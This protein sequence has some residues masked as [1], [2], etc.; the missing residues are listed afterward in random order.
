MDSFGQIGTFLSTLP[1]RGA[2]GQRGRHHGGRG[3][4]IHAP[5]EGSDEFGLAAFTMGVFLSTL[6]ARGATW[7]FFELFLRLALF[8]STLPARGATVAQ[9]LCTRSSTVISIHAPRE[10]S[11]RM[12]WMEVLRSFYF[13]PRSPRGERLPPDALTALDNLISI[14]APREGSDTPTTTTPTRSARFLSTLPARGATHRFLALN[15]HSSNFYPRS[16]RG[17]RQQMC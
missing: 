17:E 2:T 5:R 4:S 14:H 1:A 13:Y 16:P 8:L 9:R 11:D 15:G 7:L 3:I 6:P 10:G 12:R